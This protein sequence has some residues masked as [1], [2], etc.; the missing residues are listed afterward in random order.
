MEENFDGEG[1]SKETSVKKLAEEV[2]KEPV[3]EEA[4]SEMEAPM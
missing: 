3:E 1:D 2:E 4:G